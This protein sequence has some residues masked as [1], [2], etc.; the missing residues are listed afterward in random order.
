[1]ISKPDTLLLLQ[2]PPTDYQFA[3][4]N[5][6]RFECQKASIEC[7][8]C[9]EYVDEVKGTSYT[10]APTRVCSGGSWTNEDK[11]CTRYCVVMMYH[12]VLCCG[13]IQGGCVCS[14]TTIYQLSCPISHCHVHPPPPSGGY[15]RPVNQLT[16][17]TSATLSPTWKIKLTV[18]M[19][20]SLSVRSVMSHHRK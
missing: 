10:H 14:S 12:E 8:E 17:N 9:H 2:V 20:W 19:P 11:T 15:V 3:Q 16:S 7:E 1:M 4:C 6:D 5:G 18:E 13:D